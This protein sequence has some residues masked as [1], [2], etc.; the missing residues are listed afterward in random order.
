MRRP[1]LALLLPLGSLWLLNEYR[2]P[3][4]LRDFL[5]H[6]ERWTPILL[7]AGTL[8]GVNLLTRDRGP[9]DPLVNSLIGPANIPFNLFFY[10]LYL[11]FPIPFAAV[12]LGVNWRKSAALVGVPVAAVVVLHFT[13]LRAR[14]LT[15]QSALLGAFLGLAALGSMLRR[16]VRERD[17]LGLLLSLWVL[18]PAPAVAYLHLPIKYMV[19]VMPAIVLILIRTLAALPRRRELSA[20]AALVLACGAFSCVL[21]QADADFAEGGR[22]AAAEL[23]A[24]YV[25]KG[26]KVWFGGQWGFYWYA[27]EAG[28]TIANP[29][30][31]GPRPGELLA[32]GLMEGGGVTRNRFPNR[33]LVDVRHYPSPHGRTMGDG[34]GLY[35]NRVGLLVWV[36][37]PEPTND[38][39]LWRIR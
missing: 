33:D 39:E 16:Y 27:Q 29:H 21:L 26:E 1:H 3:E 28:A 22:R 20:Y 31:P 38:Y 23:I 19:G 17:R 14:S 4:A 5:R 35:S 11:A 6:P 15:E 30:E 32:V 25:A 12:W 34:G 7:A 10:L 8:I 24:P 18:I 37:N 13:L 9:A 2:P 36:W